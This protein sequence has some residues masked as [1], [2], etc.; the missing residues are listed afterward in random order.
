MSFWLSSYFNQEMCDHII[1]KLLSWLVLRIQSRLWHC[2]ASMMLWSR[3]R[4]A[5]PNVRVPPTYHDDGTKSTWPAIIDVLHYFIRQGGGG[6]ES[7]AS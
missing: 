5:C 3:R 7:T 4:I 1:P 6:S 2:Q